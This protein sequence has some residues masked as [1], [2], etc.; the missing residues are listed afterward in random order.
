MSITEETQRRWFATHVR[1][2]MSQLLERPA[3]PDAEGDIMLD[4]ETCRCWVRAD[5]QDPWGA[6]IVAY[7]AFAVPERAAVL[8]EINQL[9][10]HYFGVKVALIPPGIVTVDYRLFADAVNEENL[11][12]CVGKVMSVADKIGPML[13]AVYGGSTPLPLQ[14]SATEA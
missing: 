9:N 10:T 3:E 13:T 2:L 7:A 8:K 5:T 1:A 14:P 12:A 4:G 11:R 6:Q